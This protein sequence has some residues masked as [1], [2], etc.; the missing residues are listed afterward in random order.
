MISRLHAGSWLAVNMPKKLY[1]LSAIFFALLLGACGAMHPP[2]IPAARDNA[3]VGLLYLRQHKKFQA[4]QR[5]L[6]ALQQAPADPLVLGAFGYFLERGGRVKLAGSYYRKA[7][8]LNPHSAAAQN[9]Y[10]VY[11]CRHGLYQQSIPYFERAASNIS[12]L[13][14]DRARA[15]AKRCLAK[16]HHG[17]S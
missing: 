10:G 1:K 15:N 4:K 11:L 13:Y 5:L 14:A 12:Y 7:V 16:F 3:Q 6:L 9:N 17:R 2:N 8:E